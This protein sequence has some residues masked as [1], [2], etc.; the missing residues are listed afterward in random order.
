MRRLE[1]SCHNI[2]VARWFSGVHP[3]KASG[4]AHRALRRDIGNIV[5]SFAVSYELPDGRV[6]SHSGN[7]INPRGAYR[8]VGEY[9]MG[10]VGTITTSRQG[11]TLHLGGANPF[12]KK[13]KGDITKDATTHFVKAIRGEI[14]AENGIVESCEST[15]TAIMGRIA[16]EKGREVTWDEVFHM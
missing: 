6:Y 14:P 10:K 4:Y 7:Q 12:V 2:D 5:D 8:D 11:Y 13:T 9:F 15:L 1:Q 3:V 16:Y